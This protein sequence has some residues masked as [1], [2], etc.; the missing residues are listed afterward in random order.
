MLRL[1]EW[2]RARN[3][4]QRTMANALEISLPTYIKLESNPAKMKIEQ[5]FKVAEILNVDISD[6]IFMPLETTKCGLGG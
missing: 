2:R 1:D 3:I 6:I 5:A 4:T